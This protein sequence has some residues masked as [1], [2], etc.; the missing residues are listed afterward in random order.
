MYLHKDWNFASQNYINV[1]TLP[2]VA[3]LLAI[4]LMPIADSSF[5]AHRTVT[6]KKKHRWVLVNDFVVF[7]PKLIFPKFTFSTIYFNFTVRVFAAMFFLCSSHGIWIT[8]ALC[9]RPCLPLLQ[10]TG[11][12]RNKTVSPWAKHYYV[13]QLLEKIK[14]TGKTKWS[15]S[16]N[17]IT[18][19]TENITPDA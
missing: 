2:A 16:G 18:Q 10:P 4:A 1:N 6:W 5:N 9:R 12:R 19:S 11:N 14:H 8:R 3:Y 15:K 7:Y 13:I 17:T